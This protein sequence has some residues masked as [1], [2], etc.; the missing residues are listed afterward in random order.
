MPIGFP[1]SRR[2]RNYV[3]GYLEHIRIE[4]VSVLPLAERVLTPEDWVEL[5]AALL[6]NLD[7]LAQPDDEY[8][9]LFQ[10][11]LMTL[12]AP[13]GLGPAMTAFHVSYPRHAG[14]DPRPAGEHRTYI[15]FDPQEDA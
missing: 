7:P 5:D 3:S 11:I 9:R 6:A 8:R 14:H 15:H 1:G 13:L 2:Q 10:R 12:P 4:E